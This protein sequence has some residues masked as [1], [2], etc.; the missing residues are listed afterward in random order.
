MD[1]F[2]KNKIMYINDLSNKV[3]ETYLAPSDGI[4]IGTIMNLGAG[5]AIV[6]TLPEYILNNYTITCSKCNDI[7]R[8]L[9]APTDSAKYQKNSFYATNASITASDAGHAG[10]MQLSFTPIS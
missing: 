3:D 1:N 9:V 10:L 2:D 6:V 4:Y 7:S 5:Y 8:V